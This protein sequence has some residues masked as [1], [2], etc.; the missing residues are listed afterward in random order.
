MTG[1]STMFFAAW[2][3]RPAA[4]A[5]IVSRRDSMPI[6]VAAMV[7]SENTALIWAVT[8]SAGTSN[9]PVTPRVFCAVSAAIT[10]A[11]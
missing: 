8:N 2:R 6:L 3:S 11:P 1:S 4:T 5:S 7:R 9:T 10:E